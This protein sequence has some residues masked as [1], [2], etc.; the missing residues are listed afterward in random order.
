[1]KSEWRKVCARAIIALGLWR[2]LVARLIQLEHPHLV[3]TE[4]P[5]SIDRTRS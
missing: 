1:M 5:K 4:L 2:R 3:E